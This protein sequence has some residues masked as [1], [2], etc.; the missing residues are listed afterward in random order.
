MDDGFKH[1]VRQTGGECTSGRGMGEVVRDLGNQ[2]MDD[3]FKM[4][5]QHA[6]QNSRTF[7][8]YLSS[9]GDAFA[10]WAPMFTPPFYLITGLPC[11]IALL[12]SK[13]LCAPF[14]LVEN[15][16]KSMAYFVNPDGSYGGSSRCAG[17]KNTVYSGTSQ[18]ARTDRSLDW[19]YNSNTKKWYKLTSSKGRATLYALLGQNIYHLT[20]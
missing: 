8:D 6:A 13:V 15:T 12:L 16:F 18:E 2:A 17:C 5:L 14:W 19:I 11:I 10:A 4:S 1:R 7:G 3:N 20:V 9:V